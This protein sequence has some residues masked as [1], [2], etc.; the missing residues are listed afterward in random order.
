MV[1]NPDH[2]NRTLSGQ[3]EALGFQQVP[4]VLIVGGAGADTEVLSGLNDALTGE[5]LEAHSFNYYDVSPSLV[6]GTENQKRYQDTKVAQTVEQIDTIAEDDEKITLF[7]HSLGGPIA[8]RAALAR[9]DK[10][11][12]IVL[13]NSAGLFYDTFLRLAGRFALETILRK[14]NTLTKNGRTQTLR[15]AVDIAKNFKSFIGNAL[16]GAHSS[17]YK[18]IRAL[19]ALGVKI[20]VLQSN[21]E[22]V[23]P[24]TQ[25][26]RALEVRADRNAKNSEVIEALPVD[27]FSLYYATKKGRSRVR[28][29]SLASKYAGHDQPIIYP[30][31]AARVVAQLVEADK[32]V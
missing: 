29:H 10:I 18:D 2:I 9:A 11:D 5:G 6:N 30:K 26:Q 15:G 25:V 23:Y 12:R 4:K 32:S 24:A 3:P 13:S 17:S 14:N 21:G 1:S 19:R 8:L 27:S 16:D 22:I 7:G 20:D 28:R 31:Y